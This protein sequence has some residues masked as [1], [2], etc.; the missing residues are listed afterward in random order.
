MPIYQ[1]P[2]DAGPFVIVHDK[3]GEPA[4]AEEHLAAAGKRGAKLGGVFIP[5]RDN[6]QAAEVLEKLTTGDHNGQVQV[7]LL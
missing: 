4:V 5:C 7:D 3:A 1:V 2:E 6:D